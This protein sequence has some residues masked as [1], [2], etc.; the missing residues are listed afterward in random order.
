M[1]GVEIVIVIHIGGTG[2]VLRHSF[3]CSGD[4]VR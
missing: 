4:M 1:L 3:M 2:Y